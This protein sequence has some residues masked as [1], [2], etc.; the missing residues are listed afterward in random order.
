MKRILALTPYRI[1][2]RA[3]NRFEAIEF[4]LR[5]LRAMGY[6]PPRIID[7]GAHTG[8]FTRLALSVFPA[9]QVEMFEPQAACG[10]QLQALAR[11]EPR[12]R[13]HPAALGAPEDRAKG[14]RL[15]LHD[16]PCTG[17]HVAEAGQPVAVTCLDDLEAPAGTLLKMD[18][19]GYEM[20][21]LRGGE[22]LLEQV[23]VILTEVSFFRQGYEPR[24]VDLIAWLDQR[25]FDLF[26]VAALSGRTRDNRL[27][28][29]DLV[30]VRRGSPLLA[31]TRWA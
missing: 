9:A 15:S 30:F 13:F 7:G 19:Q 5:L 2:R 21:A 1:V 20:Q 16:G 4:S 18:L 22:R 29:G 28:Q 31:D 8:Q 12:C 6:Q 25:R 24:V 17:A 14:L 3:E 23:E 10:P 11:R 26:D 27:R